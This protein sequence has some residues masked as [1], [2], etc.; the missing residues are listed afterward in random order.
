MP[1]SQPKTPLTRISWSASTPTLTAWSPPPVRPRVTTAV[2]FNSHSNRMEP[3]PPP[4]S[5]NNDRRYIQLRRLL[6]HGNLPFPPRPPPPR[7]RIPGNQGI[8]LPVPQR[9]SPGG[10][11]EPDLRS[12]H[13]GLYRPEHHAPL[14]GTPALRAQFSLPRVLPSSTGNRG[15]DF[16]SVRRRT[17]VAQSKNPVHDFRSKRGALLGG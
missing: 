11:P 12:L 13:N 6:G 3:P 15:R 10:C 2:A 9:A 1:Q 16:Y 5:K 8:I 17:G 7:R 14:Q 4:A